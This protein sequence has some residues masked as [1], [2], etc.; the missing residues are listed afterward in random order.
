MPGGI[1]TAAASDTSPA[2]T[3]HKL[4]LVPA[5]READELSSFAGRGMASLSNRG[6]RL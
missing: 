3:G 4:S 1:T 2:Q 6:E 5:L